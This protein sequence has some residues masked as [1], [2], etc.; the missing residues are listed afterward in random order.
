MFTG[1]WSGGTHKT[2]N[3]LYRVHNG[4]RFLCVD[5]GGSIDHAKERVERVRA[6][7]CKAFRERDMVWVEA[8][9]AGAYET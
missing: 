8:E 1:R 3:D 7:G 2:M 6:D 4:C 9:R 5:Y